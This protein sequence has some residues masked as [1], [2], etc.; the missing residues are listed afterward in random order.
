MSVRINRSR[1]RRQAA[2][3]DH[4]L[5]GASLTPVH[6]ITV[7]TVILLVVVVLVCGGQPACDVIGLIAAVSAAAAQLGPWLS[8]QRPAAGLAGGA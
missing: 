6:R 4:A 1:S 8:G 5:C 3:A 7:F 2:A